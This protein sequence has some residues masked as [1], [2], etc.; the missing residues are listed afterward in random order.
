MFFLFQPTGTKMVKV[1]TWYV[2]M[3]Q[4]LGETVIYTTSF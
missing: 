1:P 2:G 4:H 3:P